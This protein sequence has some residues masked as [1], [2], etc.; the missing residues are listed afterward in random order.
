MRIT[1]AKKTECPDCGGLGYTEETAAEVQVRKHPHF[2]FV[3]VRTIK[4][5]SGCP[6]CLGLG[7]LCL[8]KK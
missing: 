1:G 5:G 4:P 3:E 2:E 7:Q 6:R 8:S